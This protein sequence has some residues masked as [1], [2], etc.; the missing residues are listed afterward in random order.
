LG[1][2]QIFTG[3]FGARFPYNGYEITGT[4]IGS[5]D[6]KNITLG[7]DFSSFVIFLLFSNRL[8]DLIDH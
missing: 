5:L 7:P 6:L 1:R 2:A 8:T 4:T 3:V